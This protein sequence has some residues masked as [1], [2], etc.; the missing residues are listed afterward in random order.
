[1]QS[2]RYIEVVGEGQFVE[3]PVRFVAEITIQVRAAKHDTA[4]NELG[5]LCRAV[6]LSL[7]DSGIDDDEIVEGGTNFLQPWYLKKKSGQ[8]GTRKVILKVDDFGRMNRA[9]EKLEPFQKSGRTSI[10]IEMR[11]PEFDASADEKAA[12]FKSAFAEAHA[13]ATRLAQEAG[14]DLDEVIQIE[15][16]RSARRASGFSGDEDWWG[17]SDRFGPAAG[18]AM[19]AAASADEFGSEVG[20]HSPTRSIFV[21]CRVRFAIAGRQTE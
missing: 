6:V 2:D 7:R 17:D 13:K 12:A 14:V 15:E 10:S 3:H 21:K 1:M 9:L 18:V 16:G 5:E 8:V 4:L 19:D 11:Q 20:T